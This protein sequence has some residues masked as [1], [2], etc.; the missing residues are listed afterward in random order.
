MLEQQE[1]ELTRTPKKAEPVYI[2]DDDDEEDEIDAIPEEDEELDSSPP[3]DLQSPPSYADTDSDCFDR[4]RG[5]YTSDSESDCRPYKTTRSGRS[6]PEYA[7][8]H[9]KSVSFDLSGDERSRSDYE[10][11]RSRT[12]DRY[13]RA[14]DSEQDTRTSASSRMPRKG[15]LRATSPCSST[16]STLER[17][18]EKPVP[19]VP[20]VA[21]IRE[22]EP[23]QLQRV[24]R[25]TS[26]ER[27]G[28][29]ERENPFRHDKAGEEDD[30]Y[31][32]IAKAINRSP[33]SPREQF[34]FSSSRSNEDLL[35][36]SHSSG[37]STPSTIISKSTENLT[38]A[39]PKVPPPTLPKPQLKKADLVR[40][41]ALET[42]QATDVGH[43]DLAVFEHDASTNTIHQVPRL[44]VRMPNKSSRPRESPP[45][46]PVN[47]AT[48]P[49]SPMC[50]PTTSSVLEESVYLEALP[51]AQRRPHDFVHENS[52]DN[53]L[54]TAEQHRQFLLHENEMR[55]QLRAPYDPAPP[56][57]IAG[58]SS[59]S[60]HNTKFAVNNPFL[61][62]CYTDIDSLP[63]PPPPAIPSTPPPPSP[64]ITTATATTP[65][66]INDNTSPTPPTPPAPPA[67]LSRHLHAS[68]N[69]LT[70]VATN[71]STSCSPIVTATATATATANYLMDAAPQQLI[72]ASPA[73]PAQLFPTAQILPVQYASLPQPQQANKLN[74]AATTA[75]S[76]VFNLLLLPGDQRQVVA[77]SSAAS[78][79]LL[80]GQVVRFICK[81]RQRRRR[82]HS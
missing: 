46:P 22:V 27:P 24:S 66:S 43:G 41:V 58:L 82:R 51:P 14:Y 26:P 2:I 44:P 29:L 5:R 60:G 20:A 72:L 63:L 36:Q 19:I 9:R 52:P 69:R 3:A 48:L 42:F 49:K 55:N 16:S 28:E 53:I 57:P 67:Q 15:I 34:L 70:A 40:N 21:R 32:Q 74:L 12:P 18:A 1:E 7:G 68:P 8:G 73:S 62:S 35:E 64:P 78:A 30:E 4:P 50:K 33:R 39:R 76:P 38:G 45:P 65:L 23:P 6:T 47:Y 61:D 59:E 13:T 10:R 56:I 17:R 71:A 79:M 54:V 80:V 81:R 75:S 77:A 37:R 25:A 11:S 31:T